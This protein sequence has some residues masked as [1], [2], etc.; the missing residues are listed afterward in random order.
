M[1]RSEEISTWEVLVVDDEPDN[2]QLASDLL[3]F[4]GAKVFQAANGRQALEVF[5]QHK[6]NIVLLDLSMPEMDGWEVY[7]QLRARP[8][9]SLPII[10][11]T[12]HAM[13]TDAEKVRAAGFDGYVS[14]PFRIHVLMGEIVAGVRKYNQ[15][16]G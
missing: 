5:E 3:E 4:S 14:K 2:L 15:S 13:P 10:A 11:L 6:P 12:A 1:V 7:R 16:G 9:G 8:D